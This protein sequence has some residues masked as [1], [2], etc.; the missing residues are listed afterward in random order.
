MEVRLYTMN[1]VDN[2]VDKTPY[3]SNLLTLT[4]VNLENPTT[5]T[6]PVLILTVTDTEDILLR[7][8]CYIPELKRYYYCEFELLR[9]KMYRITCTEDYLMSWKSHIYASNGLIVRNEN[10]RNK[11][12][13]DSEFKVQNN[14]QIQYK[15]LGVKFPIDEFTPST[16]CYIVETAGEFGGEE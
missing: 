16:V 13:E 5:V 7:N 10:I 4:N 11:Y 15:S 9:N 3:M 1:T 12:L 6:N 8:Y 2:R 14:R